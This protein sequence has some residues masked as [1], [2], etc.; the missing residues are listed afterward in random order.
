MAISK[1]LQPIGDVAYEGALPLKLGYLQNIFHVSV[2]KPYW[3][4][5]QKVT[6]YLPI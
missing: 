2:L 5:F 6:D 3:P 4:D 1:I